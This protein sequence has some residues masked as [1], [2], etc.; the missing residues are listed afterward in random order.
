M[1]LGGFLGMVLRLQVV[2]ECQVGVMAGPLIVTGL[3]KFGCLSV[4]A[5]RLFIV[6]RRCVVVFCSRRGIR[7]I[8]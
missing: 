3:E 6:L 8:R 4:M 7:K 2:R 1:S 5:S